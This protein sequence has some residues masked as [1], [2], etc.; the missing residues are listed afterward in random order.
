MRETRT[1][2]VSIAR[3][4]QEVYEAIWR[5]QDFPKWASGL[6]KTP[7]EKDGDGWRAEGPEGPIRIRFTDHNVLG[8][9]DHYVDVG[10]GPEI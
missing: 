1:V 5:P 7:L 4:W 8:V 6:C 2:S 3:P 9:M 10:V